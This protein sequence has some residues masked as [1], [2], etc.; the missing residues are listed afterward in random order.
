[1]DRNAAA[2]MPLIGAAEVAMSKNKTKKAREGETR[3]EREQ[4]RDRVDE[5]EEKQREGEREGERRIREGKREIRLGF[6]YIYIL[7]RI[8][9]GTRKK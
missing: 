6:I 1:M 5:G 9:S 2:T 3:Q 7:R 4:E 8:G